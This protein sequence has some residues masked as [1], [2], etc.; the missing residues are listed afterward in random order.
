MAAG[1]FFPVNIVKKR[2]TYEKSYF[3]VL[4]QV[5]F[6][7]PI[8]KFKNKNSHKNRFDSSGEFEVIWHF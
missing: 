8:L 1:A 3:Y 7:G 6:Q 5:D 4:R 2:E